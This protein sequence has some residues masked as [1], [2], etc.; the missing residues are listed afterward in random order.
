MMITKTSRVPVSTPSRIPDKSVVPVLLD[1]LE[2]GETP[3]IRSAAFLSLERL[4][5]AGAVDYG[6]GTGKKH[7]VAV[8]WWRNW[9]AEN[10]ETFVPDPD[11]IGTV[12]KIP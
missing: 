4:H 3:R 12:L 1:I 10:Q 2:Y 6:G 9:W 8:E 11:R 7:N 5:H